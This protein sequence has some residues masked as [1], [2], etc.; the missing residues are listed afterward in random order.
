MKNL[1]A[2][3][4]AA[5]L[6]ALAVLFYLQHQVQEKLH[7]ENAALAQQLAQ[8]Q[9]DNESLSNRLAAAGD[10]NSLS[11]KEHNELLKLRGEV[12]LLRRQTNELGKLRGENQPRYKEIQEQVQLPTQGQSEWHTTNT[13]NAARFVLLG[14]LMFSGDNNNQ[15]PTNF[16]Q[17]SNF[18]D[19]MTNQTSGIGTDAFEFVNT[20]SPKAQTSS[21]EI[22]LREQIPFRTSEGKWARTYGYA[23]G[24]VEVQVSEDGN[25]DAYEQ[26]HMVPPP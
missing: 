12:G 16:S 3:F 18:T 17:I 4:V 26:Q 24:H 14:M 10:A 5:V 7:A 20:G 8:V 22:I 1:K 9:T 13:I 6:I 21:N 15:F 25:F 11:D 2:G 23:D 19:G